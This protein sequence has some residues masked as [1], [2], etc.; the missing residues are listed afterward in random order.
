VNRKEIII[1]GGPNGAGKTTTARIL[2]PEF[3]ELHPYLNADE[4]ARRLSPDD[5]E[6]AAFAAGR[7]MILEMRAL[8]RDGTSFAFE[9]TRSGRS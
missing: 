3:L 2:L 1:L 8:V 7:Q 9:S 5:V 6:S 4:I